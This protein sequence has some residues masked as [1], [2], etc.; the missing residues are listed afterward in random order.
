MVKAPKAVSGHAECV[1]KTDQKLKAVEKVKSRKMPL[2]QAATRY[3][4]SQ[5]ELQR[6]SSD[7]VALGSKQDPNP[8]LASGE[9]L[10]VLDDVAT[11]IAQG[12]SF[13]S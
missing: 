5:S 11:R 7:E 10:G 1:M 12:Q 3:A 6:R 2:R 9:I 4:V 8:I 13:T